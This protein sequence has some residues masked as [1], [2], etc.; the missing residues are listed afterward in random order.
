MWVCVCVFYLCDP[1]EMRSIFTFVSHNCCYSFSS[2]LASF[3]AVISSMKCTMRWTHNALSF[4]IIFSFLLLFDIFKLNN[5]A[6]CC[7]DKAREKERKAN[8]QTIFAQQATSVHINI[9]RLASSCASLNS[10]KIFKMLVA[11]WFCLCND[12]WTGSLFFKCADVILFEMQKKTHC[13]FTSSINRR[14][15]YSLAIF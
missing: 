12:D 11:T 9:N 3:N 5:A 2:F 10:W 7:I 8:F 13:T 6:A 4:T 1:G 14:M 15:T